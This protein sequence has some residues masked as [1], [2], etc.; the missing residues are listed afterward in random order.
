[1]RKGHAVDGTMQDVDRGTVSQTFA[2]HL[3]FMSDLWQNFWYTWIW[4]A[5]WC[6][7]QIP[8]ATTVHL[9]DPGGFYPGP[10]V[11][12]HMRP[13]IMEQPIGPPSL[14]PFLMKGKTV[15][16]GP[17]PHCTLLHPLC[18]EVGLWKDSL[19]D[20][21]DPKWW[22]SCYDIFPLQSL[23]R[24]V[25][26]QQE[27]GIPMGPFDESFFP[28]C[29]C[30]LLPTSHSPRPAKRWDSASPPFVSENLMHS[31]IWLRVVCV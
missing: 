30:R 14:R 8:P 29:L 7:L 27:N 24:A 21:F 6:A 5:L 4:E 23:K 9:G 26:K 28:R 16:R 12:S 17:C 19:F 22:G 25:G 20:W 1:M 10:A 3:V 31:N 13:G 18:L 11:G 2:F 15:R